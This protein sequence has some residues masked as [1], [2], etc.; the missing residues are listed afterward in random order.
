AANISQEEFAEIDRL[1]PN[2]YEMVAYLDERIRGEQTR[3]DGRRIAYFMTH[4]LM[5]TQNRPYGREGSLSLWHLERAM[6]LFN[7]FEIRN[8]TRS[9]S[10]NELTARRLESL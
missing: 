4:P 5:S 9:R 10:S 1:R 3:G 7:A 2:V 6:L 8:G